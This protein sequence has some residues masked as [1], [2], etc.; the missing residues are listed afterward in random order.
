MAK[1]ILLKYPGRTRRVRV[2]LSDLDVEEYIKSQPREVN[3]G[4]LRRQFRDTNDEPNF[5]VLS[6][7]RLIKVGTPIGLHI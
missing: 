3:R 2:V 5:A 1:A 7:G 4:Y 6:G